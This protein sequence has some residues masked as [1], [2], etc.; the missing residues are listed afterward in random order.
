MPPGLHA[1]LAEVAKRE[2]RTLNA[3]LVFI[4]ERWLEGQ[5]PAR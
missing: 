3:Q 5:K 2:R 4:L 1:A